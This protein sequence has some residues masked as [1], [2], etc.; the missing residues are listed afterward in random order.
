MVSKVPRH[1]AI[2]LDGNRRYARKLGLQVLKGHEFGLNKLEDL[3]KWCQELGVKELTLYTFSTENFKRAKNEI[4]Y[5][6]SL[7]K[8]EVEKMNK[9]KGVFK[10][11]IKFNFI[12]RINMFPKAMR[13]SMLEI[14]KK[15]R[16]NKKF[17]VNFAMAYGGR[18]EIVDAVNTIIKK[19]QNKQMPSKIDENTITKHLYSQSEP[20]LVIRPGGEIRISNFLTW[21]SVYSEFIFLDKLWPEFTKEDLENCIAEFNRRERRFGK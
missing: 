8:R 12:G 17:T 11:N 5:L 13:K 16:N 21:Q 4:D 15:T 2:I 10:D 7:F 19:V 18:Q 6:F 14:V 3:F 9:K 20:D 1:V